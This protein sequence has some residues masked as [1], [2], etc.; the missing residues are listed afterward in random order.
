MIRILTYVPLLEVT[1][2]WLNKVQDE[3]LGLTVATST[4]NDL[5]SGFLG[6][7]GTFLLTKVAAPLLD[8]TP[9]LL[10]DT[11]DYRDRW[12]RVVAT[13]PSA[14]QLP[15]GAND[16][17]LDDPYTGPYTATTTWKYLGTG[18]VSDLATG[19]AVSAG[20]PPLLGAGAFRSYR[21]SVTTH[22]DA[23]SA[24]QVG[25]WLYADPTSGALY[26]YQASGVSLP[27]TLHVSATAKTGKRP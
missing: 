21:A 25:P 2:A 9:T 27:L 17:E 10:D 18:A 22:L 7:A 11:A 14:A 13:F 8:A 1:S 3:A 19:A 12:V 5:G 23:S 16:F 24:A 20:N 4:A 15:G 6:E 26:L